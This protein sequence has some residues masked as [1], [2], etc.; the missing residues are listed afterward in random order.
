MK[1]RSTSQVSDHLH[2]FG[3]GEQGAGKTKMALDFHQ[4]GQHVAIV[5][6]EAQ[7]DMCFNTR[8]LNV[9]VLFPEDADE[10][11][12]IITVPE[13][14]VAEVIHRNMGM[15]DYHPKTWVFDGIRGIQRMVFGELKKPEREVFGGSIRLPESGRGLLALPGKRGPGVPSNQDYR[16]LDLDMRNYLGGVE[17][18]PYHTIITAHAEKDYSIETRAQLTGDQ[19]QDKLVTR[20]F[21]E[22]PSL[23]GFS[24]KYDLPGLCSSFYLRMRVQ[25]NRYTFLAHAGPEFHARTRIAE[26]MPTTPIDWTNRNMYELLQSKI[27]E[28]KTKL[29]KQ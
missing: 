1:Y 17:H 23:E 21:Y 18:M 4:S 8:G 9:P 6:T 19:E 5:T 16:K 27:A 14:V 13:K 10:L 25:A 22:Y 2:I 12:A 15:P 11:V 26:V 3:Y 20:T 29:S 24:L 7:G 28:A